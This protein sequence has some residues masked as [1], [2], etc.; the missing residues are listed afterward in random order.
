[1]LWYCFVENPLWTKQTQSDDIFIVSDFQL[2]EITRMK[3]VS[4]I[5]P[6]EGQRSVQ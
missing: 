4:F 5:I 2:K 1:M 6:I 3:Y